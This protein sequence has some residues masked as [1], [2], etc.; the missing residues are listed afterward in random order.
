MDNIETGYARSTAGRMDLPGQQPDGGGFPGSIWPQKT[1][2]FTLLNGKGQL[3][4][5]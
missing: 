5:H 1:E 3:I 2:N 4:D